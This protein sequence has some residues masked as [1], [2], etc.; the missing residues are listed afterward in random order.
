MIAVDFLRHGRT[1][2]DGILLGRTTDAPLSAA[3]RQ[4]VTHQVAGRTWSAILASPLGRARETADIAAAEAGVAV[5]LAPAWQE[6]D[7]GLWDGQG[8][9]ALARDPRFAAFQADP[10]TSPPPGGET[11]ADVA[12]RLTPA[13][14]SLA[15]RTDGP[16][17]VVAHGGAIR[18]ALS[19]LLAIPLAR[20][21]A[22]RIGCATRISV[23]MGRSDTH[24]LW[25]EIVEI[26]Q[27]PQMEE[28]P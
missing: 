28:S 15:D 13:L 8:W 6:I 18:M 14:E 23:S 3:G 26:V 27:P 10:E 12:A 5:T 17:L 16:V 9:D 22:L 21:W 11:I 25:G 19:V 7:F 1:T 2:A 20:L 4:A 24:G